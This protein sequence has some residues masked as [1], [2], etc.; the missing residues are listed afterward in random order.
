MNDP[1]ANAYLKVIEEE[2]KSSAVEGTQKQVGK[3]FGDAESEKKA[4]D[5][6]PDSATENAD[7]DLEDIK[8]S[9]REL[10]T[11]GADGEA[12][13]AKL[14]KSSFNPFDALYNKILS[15]EQAF[16]FST[17]DNSLAPAD[18]SFDMGAQ[19]DLEEFD[20]ESEEEG[21]EEVTITLDREL[22]EK[23]H[24]ALA[25][26]LGNEENEEES[27]EEDSEESSEEGE[28]SS[29]ESEEVK[30]EA[31]E[32]E[33]IGHAIVDA[34]KLNKGLNNPSNKE[35]KGAVPVTKK[36]AETPHTGKDS[37]GELKPHSIGPAAKALQG[38]KNDVGGVTV[39]KT[40]FDSK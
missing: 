40:L 10:N 26:I 38:K 12:K 36:S 15:E 8:K 3:T 2:T 6:E 21:G 16:N 32:A 34:E 28:E 4:K 1:L 22:A 37:D 27:S 23:L 39:G 35:V 30:E 25:G 11:D 9:P 7:K 13:P 5:V 19:E 24:E 17:E 33:V 29:E 31:V 20:D 14:E 18:S